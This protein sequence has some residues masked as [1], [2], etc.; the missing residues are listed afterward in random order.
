[1]PAVESLG[2]SGVGQVP[3]AAD[4]VPILVS[5]PDVAV[6]LALSVPDMRLDRLQPLLAIRQF[7]PLHLLGH[8]R[9]CWGRAVLVKTVP[10]AKSQLRCN[11]PPRFDCLAAHLA[12]S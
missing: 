8:L 6:E 2:V 7:D 1:M 9:G 5:R 10:A 12:S 4:A 11:Y 3:I